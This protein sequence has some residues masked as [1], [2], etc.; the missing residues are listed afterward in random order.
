[1]D[2]NE[3][4]TGYSEAATKSM[5]AIADLVGSYAN[6]RDERLNGLAVTA[7]ASAILAIAEAI[8]AQTQELENIRHTGLNFDNRR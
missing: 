8:R 6:N 7:L 4:V 1:M 5:D 2:S 3:A